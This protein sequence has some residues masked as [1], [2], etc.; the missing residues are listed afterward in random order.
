MIIINPIN[1]AVFGSDAQ[2][3][4][5]LRM[6]PDTSYTPS[7]ND[8]SAA[9]RSVLSRDEPNHMDSSSSLPLTNTG[10]SEPRLVHREPGPNDVIC[11]RGKRAFNHPGNRRFRNMVESY[12]ERYSMAATKLEKSMLVSQIVDGVRHADPPGG[13]LRESE[14]EVTGCSRWYEVGD[15]VAREKVGQG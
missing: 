8:P 5:S 14:D 11:A 10:D 7:F 15:A 6:R 13:F 4:Q 1:A 12:M 3:Q 2:Q 9:W